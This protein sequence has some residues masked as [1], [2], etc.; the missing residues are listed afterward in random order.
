MHCFLS[1]SK[2]VLMMIGEPRFSRIRTM[3]LQLLEYGYWLGFSA[4]LEIQAINLKVI[5]LTRRARESVKKNQMLNDFICQ[6]NRK[7]EVILCGGYFFEK[8]ERIAYFS[9]RIY[10]KLNLGKYSIL[11]KIYSFWDKLFESVFMFNLPFDILHLK[12]KKCL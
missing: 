5:F 1:E 3:C 11:K 8:M 12:N 6:K 7:V 10:L 2:D 9:Y 4:I